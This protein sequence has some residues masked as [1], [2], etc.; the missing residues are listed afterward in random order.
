[1]SETVSLDEIFSACA[2]R[3]LDRHPG[4]TFGLKLLSSLMA[5]SARASPSHLKKLAIAH[6][7]GETFKDC[8]LDAVT[9][10]GNP[11]IPGLALSIRLAEAAE[12][13]NEGERRA[14]TD[15]QES[16]NNLLLEILERLPR[17]VRSFER[18]MDDCRDMFEPKFLDAFEDF[19]KPLEMMLSRQQQRELFCNVPL[20][21][22]FLKRKFT[23]S[24]PRLRDPKEVLTDSNEILHLSRGGVRGDVCLVLGTS[25]GVDARRQDGDLNDEEIDETIVQADNQPS[26]SSARK[27]PTL[28][29]SKSLLAS[30]RSP[31]ALLQGANERFPSL[32]PFPGAQFIVAGL[33]ARP[34]D[35]FRVPAMRMVLDL[36][37]YIGMIVALST[38]VL[39]R[40]Q[41]ERSLAEG[42]I[43]EQVVFRTLDWPEATCATVFIMVSSC[44]TMG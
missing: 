3:Q 10:A 27:H 24:L 26:S 42:S 28:L 2:E 34:N 7:R 17:S 15:I 30:F 32:T 16:V 6:A 14:I 18:D 41:A 31:R 4:R 1:M 9:S 36:L 22:D 29:G 33:A 38:F 5:C 21:M 13:A 35:Y 39:F 8:C 25:V 19:E 37:V 23:L 43:D 11:F 12:K 20:V 44:K 40:S